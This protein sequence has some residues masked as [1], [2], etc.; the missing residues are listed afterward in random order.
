MGQVTA[1][2]WFTSDLH[3]GHARVLEYSRRP[4]RTADE[5]DEALVKN[6]NARVGPGDQVHLLGDVSFHKPGRTLALLSR[7]NGSIGLVRGN[8]DKRM[9]EE[10]LARFAYVKD[11]HTVKVDDPDARDSWSE[12]GKSSGVQRIVL[13]HYALRV[14]ERSHY[15][16]WHLYG[17]SHGSLK[18]FDWSLSLDVGV[19]CHGYAPVSYDTIKALMSRKKWQPVDHH[20]KR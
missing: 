19:D 10:V 3:F 1:R 14:W 7:L 11:I 16:A 5:M 17:H 15:G 9:T 4:F 13:C 12:E 2:Q 8:H 18:E 6:W 20:G